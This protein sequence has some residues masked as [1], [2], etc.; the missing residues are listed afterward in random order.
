MLQ[1]LVQNKDSGGGSRKFEE[2]G[3]GVGLRC[4]IVS[5]RGVQ[6][7]VKTNGVGAWFWKYNLLLMASE[8]HIQT[9]I[10]SDVHTE[11][12]IHYS[13]KPDMLIAGI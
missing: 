11:F 9:K 4:K 1:I 5:Q 7:H 3:G 12:A 8:A 2:G 13:Q 6:K 10:A